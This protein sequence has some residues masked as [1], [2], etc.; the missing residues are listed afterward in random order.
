MAK[1]IRHRNL[2]LLLAQAREV[3]ISNFRPILNHLGVTEQQ[4]RIIRVLSEHGAMEPWQLAEQC[5]I[6]K[7]SLTG[8]LSRMEDMTLVERQR[9]PSDQRRQVVQLTGRARQLVAEAAPLVEKQYKALEAA[10][11][12]DL[13]DDLY[14]VLDRLLAMQDVEVPRIRLPLPPEV[15]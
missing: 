2:P 11:G 5:Q 15:D 12:K 8:V 6:L 14:R 4:W 13:V 3:V 9:H 1:P 7:P 10:L